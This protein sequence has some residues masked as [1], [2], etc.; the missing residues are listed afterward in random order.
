MEVPRSHLRFPLFDSLRGIAAL[1]V[2][3]FHVALFTVFMDGPVYSVVGA[4]LAHLNVG[5]PFFFLLSAF[6]LYRP[7][8]AARIAEREQPAFSGYARRR[9]LRIAPAYW[10]ALTITAIVPG[11][12][13][14]FSGNWWVYY[15][16]L[17]NFPI[18]TAQGGCA[19]DPFRCAIP[20]TWSLAIEVLFYA[21][22]PLI[23]IAL[24]WL[25]RQKRTG[26]WL[27]PELAAI[28]ILALVSVPI[29]ATPPKEGLMHAIDFSPIGRGLWF[30]LGLGLASVSVWV[31]HRSNEPGWVTTVKT[32]PWLPLVLGLALYL[33][34]SFFILEPYPL[35]LARFPLHNSDLYLIEFAAFGL[36]ALLL[37]LP[38]TFG[39]DGEGRYRW[40]LRHRLTTWLGLISYGIFLWHYPVIIFL[41]DLGALDW[42]PGMSFAVLLVT[43]LAITIP[44]AAISYYALERPLMRWGRRTFPSRQGHPAAVVGPAL[45]SAPTAATS[46]SEPAP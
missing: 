44:C 28:S 21:V 2:L 19:D 5:V 13:G 7:F 22:L 33:A 14:A 1:S 26:S 45:T 29:Q 8:V 10:A 39:G 25:G 11:M 38:A 6:L 40:F 23:V 3:V 34:V 46:D 12:A 36:V 18:Y 32:K 37:V 30:A 27:V 41:I 17:Q 16:L 15:G 4:F 43:T 35:P 20:P 42:A 31:G 9:F 24:A